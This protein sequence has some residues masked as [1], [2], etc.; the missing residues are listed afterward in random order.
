MSD[1]PEHL[2]G[3]QGDVLVHEDADAMAGATAALLADAAADA[4]ATRGRFDIALSG[5]TTPIALF[6]RLTRAPYRSDIDWPT[7][8]VYFS[9]ERAVPLDDADSNYRLVHEHLLTHV[10]IDPG[11]VRPMPADRSDLDTAADEYA[12][13]LHGDLPPGPA[14]P[15][16]APR[17]DCVVLGLGTNGHTA[18]LFPGTPA[19]NVIDRWVTRGR[20][21]Y[22]PFDRLTLTYPTINA[23]TLV[24]FLVS[25]A[26][27]AEAL[28]ATAAGTTP[29][30]G[31][32]PS[33]GRVLWLLDS[34]AAGK[35]RS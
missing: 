32:R 5:G 24:V 22:A 10:P 1:L 25:G 18:S 9:D 6:D 30:A 15:T 23:A 33:D 2:R 26:S 21:D 11:R 29:A 19:L 17:L 7:W 20:G 27:K 31:V 4:C 13:T 3:L 35:P 8:A 14:G 16:G 34:A 28:R 12:V